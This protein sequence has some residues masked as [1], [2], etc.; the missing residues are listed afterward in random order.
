MLKNDCNC[1]KGE[2]EYFFHCLSNII[3][4]ILFFYFYSL[5]SSP[6]KRKKNFHRPLS[7]NEQA[8]ETEN[9]GWICFFAFVIF[10]FETRNYEGEKTSLH[11]NKLSFI[12]YSN[13]YFIEKERSVKLLLAC[14]RWQKNGSLIQFTTLAQCAK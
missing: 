1:V 7:M 8:L 6:E 13:Y 10:F 11:Y 9:C 14:I 3:T 2:R 5:H 12:I 4:I